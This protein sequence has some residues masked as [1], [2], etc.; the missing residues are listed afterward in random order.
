MVLIALLGNRSA[1]KTTVEKYLVE[2]HNFIADQFARSL[3]E[4]IGRIC[5]DFNDDQLYGNLKEV[6]DERWGV[7][8]R[9]V[10]Q[11]Y[12]EHIRNIS[13]VLLPE[14]EG[15]FWVKGLSLRLA[16][17]NENVVIGDLRMPHE[18]KYIKDRGG[19]IIKLV[20]NFG[21]ISSRTEGSEN[22]V[23]NKDQFSQ[24]YSET[25]VSECPYDFLI[26]NNG[27]LDDLYNKI[28]EYLTFP[29]EMRISS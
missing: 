24:H 10:F 20:R 15:N 12:G 9:A 16:D 21:E 18:A 7:S 14:I 1:G 22:Y 29:T 17:S 6:I 4:G 5:F 27:S 23:G 8:P 25:A 11:F 2:Q 13:S 28:R 3:K 19:V 26:E